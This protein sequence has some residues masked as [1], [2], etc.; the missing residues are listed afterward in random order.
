MCI[1]GGQGIKVEAKEHRWGVGNV[2][3]GLGLCGDNGGH[4]HYSKG[5]YDDNG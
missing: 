4:K 5:L 1:D 2:S 3:G